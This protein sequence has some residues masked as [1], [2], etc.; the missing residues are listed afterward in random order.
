MPLF[1]KRPRQLARTIRRGI[2][3]GEIEN[4]FLVLR[5][6]TTMPYP[7]VSGQPP[8]VGLN[9]TGTLFGLSY[10]SNDAGVNFSRVS[11]FNFR[12]SLVVAAQPG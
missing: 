11:T 8:L 2:G 12:F 7:G 3:E 4:V 10:I 1:A 5:I 6:P 9:N